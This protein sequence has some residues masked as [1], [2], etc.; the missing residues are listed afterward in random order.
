MADASATLLA[1]WHLGLRELL[2]LTTVAITVS[3]LDDLF[4]DLVYFTRTAWRRLTI[5]ARHRRATAQSLRRSDPAPIAILVPAWDEAA[6][7][8]TMLAATLARLDYPR[9]RLFV[10][11]YPNDP[12]GQAA[13][14]RVRDAR[15][16]MVLC[17]RPGPTT[18]ADCLNHLWA[19]ALA[20]EARC[21]ERFKAMVLH[22]AEDVVHPQELW[23]FDALVPRLALVQLPVLPLPD[24]GSRW[25]SGH[26]L[27]EFA[28]N[29]TKDMVVREA[30][31]AA[32]P[33]AGV[34]CAFDR[35]CLARIAASRSDG[36]F[37]AESLT[38][39][40]ELGHRIKALGGR[41]G[42]VRVRSGDER[43]VVAT[44]EHFP[45]TF[46]AALRQKSRWLVGIALSGWDRLGW[47]GG[48]G[49]RYMLLRDRKAMPVALLT[50]LG[51]AVAALVAAD[52]L[53]RRQWSAAAAMPPL[54]GG[55]LA[56]LL[57]GNAGL[58]AWRLVLRAGF[59]AHA[60][61]F[62]EGLLAIPRA[63]AS[64]IINAAAAWAAIHRYRDIVAGRRRQH[65][66]KTAHRF[67]ASDA[68]AAASPFAEALPPLAAAAE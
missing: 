56:A 47:Q 67:P 7:I 66:D 22:D 38:E 28:E 21:G 32:V 60:H 1:A 40:Y 6:V 49:S 43:V 9:Y 23:V 11:V 20:H 3:G 53:L 34:A 63:L 62:A 26:Y 15:L 44:R 59:T 5:Y 13:V 4:I 19:A 16:E 33:S 45:A 29:H 68:P 51:Y 10:G 35:E 41:A 27:D 50:A 65:W 18:K 55:G 57:W 46:D 14:G 12:A 48:L 25:V 37:D 24:R 2:M 52:W 39:D 36:P 61:G 54:V 64:N 58:L 42:L 31:G 17:S 8:G 30:L